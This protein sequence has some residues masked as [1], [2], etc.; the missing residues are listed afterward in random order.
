MSPVFKCS[1]SL[2]IVAVLAGCLTASDNGKST[3]PTGLAAIEIDGATFSVADLQRKSSGALF[4]ARNALFEA[5]RKA[6]DEFI[7]DY[8]LDR[9][10]KKENITVEQLL[11]RRVYST[12][13]EPSEEALRVYYDG[14]DTTESFDAVRDKIRDVIRQRWMTK[15]KAAYVKSLRSKANVTLRLAPPRAQITAENTPVRG[16]AAAAV[17]V[18]EFADYECPYCQQIEPAVAKLEAAYKGR[19]AFAY[20]DVPLPMHA[21]AQKAAEAAHCAGAQGKYW[22]YHDLL[23][24][25]KQYD[26][27]QLKEHARTLKLDGKAFDQCLDSGAQAERIKASVAEAQSIG[28]PGTPGFFVNGRFINGAVDY[29]ILQQII[30]EELRATSSSMAEARKQVNET[31]KNQN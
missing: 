11:E 5:E 24:A 8:L 12:F 9:E 28:L 20:K 2:L 30:E 15:A 21:H 6:A 10:A 7:N 3:T 29:Q 22:E 16:A 26:V 18:V 14:I 27:A 17:T 25:T 31:A 13:K 19:I 4:Q 23:F 1:K